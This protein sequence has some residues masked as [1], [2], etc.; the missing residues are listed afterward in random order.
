MQRKISG[1][2]TAYIKLAKT[3]LETC[4]NDSIDGKEND[5]ESIRIMLSEDYEDWF[6]VICYIAGFDSITTRIILEQNLNC[7]AILDTKAVETIEYRQ[8]RQHYG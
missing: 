7:K 8:E 2:D 5:K 4:F 3:I 1:T 6:D